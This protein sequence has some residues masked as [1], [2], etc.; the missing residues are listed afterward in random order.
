VAGDPAKSLLIQAVKWANKDLQMP[1]KN[2][3]SGTQ[4]ADLESWIKAGAPD[5]RSGPRTLTKIEQH[6]EAEEAL[7]APARGRSQTCVT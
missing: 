6:L 4:I 5:P 3:L 1:P 2:K 7:V